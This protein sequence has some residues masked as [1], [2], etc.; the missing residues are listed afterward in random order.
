VLTTGTAAGLAG[1][2]LFV[3]IHSILIFPIWTRF[4]GHLPF[5]WIAGV[6]LA[7][8]FDQAARVP[9]RRAAAAGARFGLVMFATLAPSTAFSNSLRLAGAHANDSQ[10]FVGTIAFAIAAGAAAGWLFTRRRAG[11][12]AFATATLA[13]TIAMGGAIPV[14]NGPRAALLYAGF[15]PICIGSGIVLAVARGHLRS[16]DL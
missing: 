4:I 10:G 3:V 16:E 7:A 11:A 1:A 9:Q 6:A 13:L 15:L 8:A 5:A 14:V 12:V 2:A